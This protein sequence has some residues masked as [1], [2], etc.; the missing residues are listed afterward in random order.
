MY[1]KF[2]ITT[3]GVL[4]FGRVY[5]HKHLLY[6][7]DLGCNGGGFWEV[8]P[9]RGIIILHGRSADFGGPDFGSGVRCVEWGRELMPMPVFYAPNYPNLDPLEIVWV[10]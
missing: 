3:D 5:L 4:R 1:P 10:V 6:A 8:E 7:D 9:Q 2:I